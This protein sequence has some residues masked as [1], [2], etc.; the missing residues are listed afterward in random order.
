MNNAGI[1]RDLIFHRMT[2]GSVERRHRGAPE[3]HV[4]RLPPRR[5]HFRKQESGSYVHFTSTSGLIGNFGQANYSAAKL[6]IAALSKSIALDMKRYNV[7]SNCL[8][9]FAWTRMTGSI[10]AETEAE[11]PRRE[12][13]A[14]GPGEE[15]AALRLPRSPTPPRKSTG[16]SSARA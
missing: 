3:R 14:D 6:G 16:R 2:R 11:G 5:A 7:R 15:R 1:L 4:L 10:P 8:A 9:P 12:D 13:H